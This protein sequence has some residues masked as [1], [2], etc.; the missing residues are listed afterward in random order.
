L[1]PRDASI[2][3]GLAKL[4]RPSL[5]SGY[6]YRG[7]GLT[8]GKS[9]ILYNDYRSAAHEWSHYRLQFKLQGVNFYPKYLYKAIFQGHGFGE[10]HPYENYIY[11]LF[12]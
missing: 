5:P 9:L 11:N 4:F 3:G 8:M 12:K 2:L 7:G 10:E 6:E 1:T